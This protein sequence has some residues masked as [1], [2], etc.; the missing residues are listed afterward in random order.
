MFI[1]HGGSFE[2]VVAK[3]RDDIGEIIC[4][5]VVY[6]TGPVS[7]DFFSDFDD[8]IASIFIKFRLILI[9]GDLNIHLDQLTAK[10]T[11]KLNE[12]VSSYG[13]TQLVKGT[14]HKH[15]HT[16]DVVIASHKLLKY[17]YVNKNLTDVFRTCDHMPV[18]FSFNSASSNLAS[19]EMKQITFRDFKG[20]DSTLLSADFLN[21]FNEASSRPENSFNDRIVWYNES[22][23]SILDD[24]APL[25]TKNIKDRPTA[26]WFDGE[27][28][29]LRNKRRKA[30]KNWKKTGTAAARLA[31]EE[32]RGK[33]T[34]LANTKKKDFFQREFA[35]H[36]YSTKSLFRFVNNFMDKDEKLILPPTESLKEVVDNFNN[37]FQEKIESI[38]SSFPPNVSHDQR[39]SDDIYSGDKMATFEPTTLSEIE[40]I[41]KSTEFKSSTVDPLPPA[42]LKENL[43]IFIPVLCDLVNASLDSGSIDGAKLAHIT[44]LIKGMNLDNSEYKNYRPISNLSFVGKLIERV[45]LRRLNKHMTENNLHASQQSGY[46]KSHSTETVKHYYSEW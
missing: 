25:L 15:G 29:Q 12:L 19:N 2:S 1:K 22:C 46:K 4:C 18:L 8:F 38:R 35:K 5:A 13:L 40:E 42:I 34:S 45:V 17:V 7:D 9:C 27:Y 26:P 23:T 16:L 33:C 28:K 39:E 21:V 32:V 43:D 11:N 3:F 6:R 41:L 30:E 36:N 20:I 10:T 14:T 24:H 44:P 31:Y 37:F